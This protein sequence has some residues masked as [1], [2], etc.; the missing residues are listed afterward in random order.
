MEKTYIG[1]D[2]GG[3]S[4]KLAEARRDGT[5]LREKQVP[6]GRLDQQEAFGLIVRELDGFMPQAS[7]APAAVG[8][9]LAGRVDA[10]NGRWLEI[11][12]DR[13]GKMELRRLLE[14]RYG[15]PCFM[16]NDVRSAAK[17]EA[18]FGKGK[19]LSDWVYIN[20]GTG[21][22]AATFSG[23][24]P[25]TGGHW[26]AG[27]AGHTG[28][29]IA[30]HAPCACGRPDCVEPVAS[31]LGIDTCSRLLAENYPDTRL[32]IPENGR[33]NPKDVFVLYDSDPLCRTL[34]ENAAQALANLIM[35]LV[36][37]CDPEAVIL[38]G[39]VMQGGFLYERILEKIHA[40]TVRYVTKGIQLSALPPQTVG[41]L[42]ACAN[43]IDGMED[44]YEDRDRERRA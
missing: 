34:T 32:K 36:R 33:V 28:S 19:G 4:L 10:K 40:Y 38:G 31:G 12:H 39:G 20:V 26:N 41:L 2:L 23:G 27:E 21:V 13:P 43:G 18:L 5:I 3:T 9:G 1:L 35:N 8:L 22:A 7:G 37:F 15:L 24:R 44:R 25:V 17:A 6:S 14:E 11:D 16:D 42:G 29:G 30:F